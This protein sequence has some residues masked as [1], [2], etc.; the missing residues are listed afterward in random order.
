MESILRKL[1]TYTKFIVGFLVQLAKTFY[2]IFLFEKY[3]TVNEEFRQQSDK[4]MH[5]KTILTQ[6]SEHFKGRCY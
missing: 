2:S 6:F 1:F 5:A 4:F 3:V